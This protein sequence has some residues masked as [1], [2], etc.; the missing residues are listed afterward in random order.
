MTLTLLLPSLLPLLRL[1]TQHNVQWC[2]LFGY[3]LHPCT[4]PDG[5]TRRHA[6]STQVVIDPRFLEPG[7]HIADRLFLARMLTNLKQVYLLTQQ[8]ELGLRVVRCA[9][10]LRCLGCMYCLYRLRCQGCLYSSFSWGSG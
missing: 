9:A 5:L 10:R 6:S 3:R 2:L 7:R 4:W 8:F 1:A